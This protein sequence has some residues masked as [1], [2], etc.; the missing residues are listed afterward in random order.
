MMLQDRG[1]N[2]PEYLSLQAE[3]FMDA[4]RERPEIGNIL[5]TFRANVPQIFADVDKDMVLKLGV[6]PADV[7]T[8]LGSFLGGG[9]DRSLPKKP[10]GRHSWRASSCRVEICVWS[11][12]TGG[13][14][15][16]QGV[17]RNLEGIT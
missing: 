14:G 8:T 2:T 9:S 11:A 5:S 1:G 10:Q 17:T 7:N 15:R 6:S 12:R 3:A 4:A 16:R 13:D